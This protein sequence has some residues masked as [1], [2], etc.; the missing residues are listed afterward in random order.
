[1][2]HQF[3]K[4]I[5]VQFLNFFLKVDDH[6]VLIYFDN[7]LIPTKTKKNN[8]KM[9]SRV[10]QIMSENHLEMRL[11]EWHFLQDS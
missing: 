5:F 10:L 6:K 11:D 7:I 9:L 2:P 4:G 1:M 8:L 3:F